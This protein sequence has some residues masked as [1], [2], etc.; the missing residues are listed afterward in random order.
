G[1]LPPG[2]SRPRRA[3]RPGRAATRRARCGGC[4]RDP[5]N[6][7]RT[8]HQKGCGCTRCVGFTNGNVV[9][10]KHGARS[11]VTLAP[12]AAELADGLRQ[13]V[14]AVSKSD[15]P[16]TRLLALALARVEAANAWLDEVGLLRE[17]G[18][19]QGVLK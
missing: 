5:V 11:M 19:P 4:G 16:S 14:P 15:E 7:G 2:S 13:I 12:R 9:A 18:T 8:K 6:H 17:D 3:C 1:G 10:L